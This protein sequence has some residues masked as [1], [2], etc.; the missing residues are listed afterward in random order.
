MRLAFQA[1]PEE[2]P[3]VHRRSDQAGAGRGRE[4]QGDEVLDPLP[5]GRLRELGGEGHGQQE[6]EQDLD[7]GQGH[8]ELVQ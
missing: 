6:G 4:Q 1:L 7:S 2:D 5:L 3:V 8:A